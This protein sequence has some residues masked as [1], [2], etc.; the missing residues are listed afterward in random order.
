MSE[1]QKGV[2]NFIQNELSLY[3]EKCEELVSKSYAN[4]MVYIEKLE[5]EAKSKDQIINNP[6]VSLE[7]LTCY[8]NRNAVIDN[9]V[10]SPSLLETLPQSYQTG[11]LLETRFCQRYYQTSFKQ[12]KQ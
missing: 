12:R 1:V 11:N 7:S 4:G 8:P 2:E 6:L 9:T 5:K 3:K 10:T